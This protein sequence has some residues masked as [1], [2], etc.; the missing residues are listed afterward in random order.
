MKSKNDRQMSPP[1]SFA[2]RLALHTVRSVF[3]S[4]GYRERV[5]G[6]VI[7]VV[8]PVITG[9][10][11]PVR[12]RSEKKKRIRRIIWIRGVEAQS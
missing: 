7:G 2:I 8:E 1:F 9:V 5:L 12:Y 10:C 4:P 3:K 11:G 6:L